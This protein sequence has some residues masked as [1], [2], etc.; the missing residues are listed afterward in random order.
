VDAYWVLLVTRVSSREPLYGLLPLCIYKMTK[1]C[2]KFE[3]WTYIC[4]YLLEIVQ[5]RLLFPSICDWLSASWQQCWWKL[6][7]EK[8]SSASNWFLTVREWQ[9]VLGSAKSADLTALF[10][11]CYHVELSGI[12]FW[13]A[14]SGTSTLQK[15]ISMIRTTS[16]EVDVGVSPWVTAELSEWT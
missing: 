16:E 12:L 4:R 1:W 2:S 14:R 7:I 15:W 9:Y 6:W 3:F 13:D 8:S 10:L 11:K 5:R